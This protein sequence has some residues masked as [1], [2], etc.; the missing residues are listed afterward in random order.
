MIGYCKCLVFTCFADDSTFRSHVSDISCYN[1]CL[2]NL[3]EG[4]NIGDNFNIPN[5]KLH[6]IIIRHFLCYLEINK[7]HK[8]QK[9]IGIAKKMDIYTTRFELKENRKAYRYNSIGQTSIV[10][11]WIVIVK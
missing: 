9:Y 11:G 2:Y 1:N 4:I 7:W 3:Y 6:D 8:H 5:W 10:I